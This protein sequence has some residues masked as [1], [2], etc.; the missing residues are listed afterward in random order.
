MAHSS[1]ARA[2]ILLSVL[3][4]G[5]G[6]LTG[7]ADLTSTNL[8]RLTR[9]WE[10]FEA[11]ERPVRVMS[12]GDSLGNH[13]RSLQRPLFNRFVAKAGS[14]GFSLPDRYN[15]LAAALGGGASY[16]GITTNWWT[17][18]FSVSSGGFI[19][20]TNRLDPLSSVLC[21]EVGIFWIARPEGGE[22]ALSASVGGGP[23]ATLRLLDGY[24]P[25]P[26]GRFTNLPVARARYQLRVDGL[27]GTNLVLGP[28]FLDRET[29][30]VCQTFLAMDG[31][32]LSQIF[33]VPPAVLE[34]VF[35][36]LRPDL[37]VWHMKEYSGVGPVPVSNGLVRLEALLRA[38]A[39]QADLLYIGTPYEQRD[40][41]NA[42]TVGQNEVVRAAAVRD[43]RAY[44]DGMNP[45]VSYS[46]MLSL[47]F[48]DDAVHP[49]NT[50]YNF[51]A[52]LLYREA[53]FF[54][55]RVDRRLDHRLSDG[56]FVLEWRTTN[57]L[58]YTLEASMNL[59]VWT[60][61]LTRPGDGQPQS[62]TNNATS[63]AQRFHRLRLDA[64]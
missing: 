20:W 11:A 34:P 47:G 46:H 5:M 61:L 56:Q 42:V 43:R 52:D 19:W 28:H 44:F 21:D 53:G 54:A 59:T 45:C 17:W 9:F 6:R 48:L 50:C 40:V 33:A 49:S 14:A 23:W 13:Y 57:S 15:T 12:F 64:P 38:T 3:L 36:A 39:P 60:N 32:A 22:L 55:L 8:D 25:S 16:V 10:V 31:A 51:L 62:V 18:H 37:L 58:I 35:A 26:A 30:G 27:T 41:T 24:A 2:A 4:L 7:L 63:P 29:T 1:V